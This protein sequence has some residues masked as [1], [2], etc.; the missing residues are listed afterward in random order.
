M[1]RIN[2][3]IIL[4]VEDCV[5]IGLKIAI[6]IGKRQVENEEKEGSEVEKSSGVK[7]A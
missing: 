6:I 2:E 3:S 5:V 7:L 4:E 1:N